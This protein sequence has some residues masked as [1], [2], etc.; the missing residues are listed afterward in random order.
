[1]E[2]NRTSNNFD[3]LRLLF[4]SIVAIVHC[5]RLSEVEVLSGI[6]QYLSSEVAVDSFFVISGFLIFM[7]FE[8]SKSLS[9]YASKRYR[10]IYPGYIFVIIL[11]SILL[12]SVSSK[13]LLEYVS[14][15]LLKYILFNSLTLNFV[16]PALPGVFENNPIQAVNGALWTIKIEIMF[17]IVV[18]FIAFLLSRFNKAYILILIYII[19]ITYSLSMLWLFSNS[20]A[21]IY[22]KLERQLPGQLAFFISGAVAYYFYNYFHKN[23]FLLLTLSILIIFLY[24]YITELYIFYPI[25]LA[26]IVLFFANFFKYLGNF[27]RFGDFSYGVYIWHFPIAQIFVFY[28]MFVNPLLGIGLYVVSVFFVSYLSWHLIEKRYLYK[29]SYYIVSERDSITNK[30]S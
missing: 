1:M 20:G 13:S 29:S 25:S 16:H 15:D 5:S 12:Y 19:S 6:G 11:C 14:P 3:F 23:R 17:Y 27:G 28:N 30:S 9:D 22:V 2:I 21:E 26:V 4:A 10:R 7:S 18:P 8:S 24:K